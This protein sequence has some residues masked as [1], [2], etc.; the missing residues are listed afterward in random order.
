MLQSLREE[1]E[2]KRHVLLSLGANSLT[3]LFKEVRVVKEFMECYPSVPILK[4]I[5]KQFLLC[6]PYVVP[7]Q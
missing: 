1:T 2:G 5:R 3:S 7:E 6:N 4:L